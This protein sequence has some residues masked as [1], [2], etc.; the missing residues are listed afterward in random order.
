VKPAIEV[1]GAVIIRDGLVFC[2]QR[3]PYGS[4]AGLWEFPG[5]KVEPGE[6]MGVALAREIQEEL[7]CHVAVGERVTTTAHNYDFGLVRLTT[8][9]CELL[10]EEPLLT[11]HASE[12]WAGPEQL[13]GLNW[14]PADIPAV[15]IV[16]NRLLSAKPWRGGLKG[17]RFG[18]TKSKRPGVHD[19]FGGS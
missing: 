4:L 9:Y 12:L 15:D 18:L 14:A 19:E 17:A 16:G 7:L 8:F 11:E 3:G 2:V 13:A 10:D 5:G 1:V 6:E